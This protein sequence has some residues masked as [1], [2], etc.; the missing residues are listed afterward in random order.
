MAR[1]WSACRIR[2]RFFCTTA[3]N[4]VQASEQ[5]AIHRLLDGNAQ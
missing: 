5:K 3:V 1:Y 2:H 4:A